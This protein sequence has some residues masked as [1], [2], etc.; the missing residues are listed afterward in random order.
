MMASGSVRR[1]YSCFSPRA[2]PSDDEPFE[3][4]RRARRGCQDK[5]SSCD[6]A[7]DGLEQELKTADIEERAAGRKLRLR[8]RC[9]CEHLLQRMEYDRDVVG[10]VAVS[11]THLTLPTNR[12]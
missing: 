6:D 3:E 12:E 8:S 4:D 9:K 5:S 11:Y 10:M 2:M 7:G 1:K